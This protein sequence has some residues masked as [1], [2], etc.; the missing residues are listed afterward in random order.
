VGLAP[1][2]NFTTSEFMLSALKRARV[3]LRQKINILL[4]L[5]A[6]HMYDIRCDV[7]LYSS[8]ALTPDRRIGSRHL[9]RRVHPVLPVSVWPAFPV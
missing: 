9:F 1:G 5:N 4:F 2:A 7:N 6:T 3:F 8:G